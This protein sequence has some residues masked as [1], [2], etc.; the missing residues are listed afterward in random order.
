MVEA[1]EA[2]LKDAKDAAAQGADLVEYRID[3]AMDLDPRTGIGIAQQ[4]A[5]Q[6]P[7]A[8]IITCRHKREGGEFEGDENDRLELFEAVCDGLHVPAYIDIEFAA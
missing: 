6:S 1:F 8:C 4:L 5:D 2:A 7:I 3:P